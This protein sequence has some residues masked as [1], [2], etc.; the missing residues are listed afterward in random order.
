MLCTIGGSEYNNL[1]SLGNTFKL[2]FHARRVKQGNCM[3][4]LTKLRHVNIY[5]ICFQFV[6]MYHVQEMIK[7]MKPAVSE[8]PNSAPQKIYICIYIKSNILISHGA[9]H[10]GRTY[11]F[12]TC[13]LLDSLDFSPEAVHIFILLLECF[14]DY[15]V[16][17]WF[18]P[19]IWFPSL[20]RSIVILL[21]TLFMTPGKCILFPWLCVIIFC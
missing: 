13:T 10:L 9:S 12:K 16:F 17:W 2:S 3:M 18:L 7:Y 21:G 20:T 8:T 11:M 14:V 4:F 6:C 19:R 15:F 5:I 1:W